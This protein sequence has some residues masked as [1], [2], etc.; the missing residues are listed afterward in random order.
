MT[1]QEFF[2][3]IAFI[4][5]IVLP[6]AYLVYLLV[7]EHMLYKKLEQRDT[8]FKIMMMQLDREEHNK[9]QERKLDEFFN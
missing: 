6:I 4:V 2:A 9:K 7:D 5:L 1:I 3:V 8:A